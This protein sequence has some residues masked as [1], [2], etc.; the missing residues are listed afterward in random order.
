MHVCTVHSVKN[1]DVIWCKSDPLLT[2]LLTAEKSGNMEL[3]DQSTAVEIL[4]ENGKAT[5]VKYIDNNTGLEYVQPSDIVVLAGFVLQIQNY[6]FTLR[7][8]SLIIPKL[9]RV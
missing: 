5:A 1:M 2:V 3:R 6:Y 4:H 8:V 9:K 7:L